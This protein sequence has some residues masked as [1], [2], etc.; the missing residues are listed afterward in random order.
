MTSVPAG[1]TEDATEASRDGSQ[2]SI[3]PSLAAV[4]V[5]ALLAELLD[6][7]GELVG[8][9]TADG[10]AV[11]MN[12]AGRALLGR[13]ADEIAGMPVS[14]F[15]PPGIAARLADE[16]LPI[17]RRDGRWAGETELLRKDG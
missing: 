2:A 11:S 5:Q 10:I 1:E 6:G 12:R 16:W 8:V 7:T 9:C 17:A 15:H 14:R 13:D 4:D 3:D